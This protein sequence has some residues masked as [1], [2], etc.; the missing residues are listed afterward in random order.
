MMPDA[1][2]QNLSDTVQ[3]ARTQTGN[4]GRLH[5]LATWEKGKGEPA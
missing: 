4:T 5:L 3:R 1:L 2:A